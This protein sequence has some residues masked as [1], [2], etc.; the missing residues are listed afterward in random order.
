MPVRKSQNPLLTFR[1]SFF[2]MLKGLF[3]DLSA[4][5]SRWR[6][7]YTSLPQIVVN[8][9]FTY[10]RWDPVSWQWG[11]AAPSAVTDL[12]RWLRHR[13]K[14]YDGIAFEICQVSL[15]V[16]HRAYN[17]TFRVLSGAPSMLAGLMV[18]PSTVTQ[19]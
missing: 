3:D 4:W 9:Q 19:L 10:T 18:A 17:G 1:R 2:M 7:D 12:I 6:G 16:R 8:A 14:W 11:R 15:I 13:S 5:C